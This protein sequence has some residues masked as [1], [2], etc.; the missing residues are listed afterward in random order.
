M[1]VVALVIYDRFDNLAEWIRCW[2]MCET[3]GA[4]LVVIHNFESS[5]ARDVYST[6]CAEAGVTYISRDNIG[7]D[8]GAFQDVCRKRLVGFPEY[9]RLIWVTD[10]TLPM[11][12]DFIMQYTNEL[13]SEVGCVAMQLSYERKIHIRTTG[14]CITRETAEKLEFHCDPIVTKEDCWQFEH[15]H[16]SKTFL[17][18]LFDMEL[19][20]VQI[21]DDV[22]VSPLWDTG[23]NIKHKREEEHYLIFPK[24]APSNKKVAVICPIYNSYPEIVSSMINQTH[25]NWHLFLIHDGKSTKNI[26]AI[27][28][29]AADS[30]ITYEETEVRR[31]SW[32]NYLRQEWLEKLKDSDFD[33]IVVT[34]ADNQH[35]P[36]YCEYMINGFQEDTV[37][38][39]CEKMIHSY[40]GWNIIDCKLAQGYLDAAGMMVRKDV[41][42]EVG[43]KHVKAHSGDWLYFKEMIDKYGEDKFVKV[44]GV[45]F[46]HN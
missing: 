31:Q 29:A 35:F 9:N 43:W 30:R 40:T 3:E 12:R 1:T 14:F 21:E 11:R 45:L 25:R 34:N 15:R 8:I 28:D 46:S 18:Q 23:H 2:N 19:S 4:H 24:P 32:G 44:K 17:H 6:H 20:V 36:T 39:Y 22:R 33:Y 5:V 38:V 13:N 41:A 27:V 10:D 7:Y 42:C 16:E 37:G 26:K